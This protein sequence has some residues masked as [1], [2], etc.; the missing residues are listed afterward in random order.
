MKRGPAG[1]VRASQAA[2]H[3]ALAVFLGDVVTEIEATSAGALT[4][5]V[6]QSAQRVGGHDPSD[7]SSSRGW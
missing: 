5:D 6:R 2:C 1:G 3:D 4:L 7:L